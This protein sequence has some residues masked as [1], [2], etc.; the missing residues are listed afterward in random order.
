MAK[1]DKRRDGR[2][3]D[4]EDDLPSA[5]EMRITL[6]RLARLM[7]QASHGD[8]LIPVQWE[9][10][11]YLA[12]A[13]RLSNAPIALSRY[14]GTTKGTVSQTLAALEKKGLLTKSGRD[15]ND[16]SLILQLTA[17]ADLLLARDPLTALAADMEALAGKTKRRL[18]RGL[19]ELLFHEAQRQAAPQ[20]G[21]CAACRYFRE[22][23]HDG[24]DTCMKDKATLDPAEQQRLCIEFTIR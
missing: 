16:R 2:K 6:E 14:L 11:R 23:G 18:A 4:L 19:S 15:G 5:G 7:R 13:N 3:D 22:G 8:G 1:K 12:R 9:A 10:L 24:A 21:T 17:A 20:F